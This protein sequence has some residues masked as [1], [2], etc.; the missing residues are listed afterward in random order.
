MSNPP[1]K[2]ARILIVDDET[3]I[4]SLIQRMLSGTYELTLAGSLEESMEKIQ[5]H[6]FDLLLTDLRLPDGDGMEIVKHFK[7]KR[8]Q[9]P[10]LVMTGSLTPEERLAQ[11]PLNGIR[12]CIQKPFEVAVLQQAI[13][14]ALEVLRV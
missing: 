5:T 4:C 6:D 12:Q 14:D 2:R 8:P 11:I 3:V 7:A 13:R 9:A 1:E 10:V